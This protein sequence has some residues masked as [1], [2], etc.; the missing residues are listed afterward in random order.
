MVVFLCGI[1]LGVDL[2]AI[3]NSGLVNKWGREYEGSVGC[4]RLTSLRDP[5]LL[6]LAERFAGMLTSR[7][8]KGFAITPLITQ[9]FWVSQYDLPSLAR[10]RAQKNCEEEALLIFE[11]ER[12]KYLVIYSLYSFLEI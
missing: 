11:T 7:D 5:D 1:V 3:T 4:R 2:V 12:D 10:Q 6:V 8:W 9:A